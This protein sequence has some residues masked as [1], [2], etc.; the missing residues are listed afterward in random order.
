[1]L[2]EYSRVDEVYQS[3]KQI[4]KARVM[5]LDLICMVKFSQSYVA[6]YKREY[7]RAEL[8]NESVQTKGMT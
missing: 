1:M 5:A 2:E 3:H 8:L 4:K 6:C 7:L